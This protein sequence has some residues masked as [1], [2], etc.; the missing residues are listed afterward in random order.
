MWQSACPPGCLLSTH[1]V[2]LTQ[3]LPVL[4]PNF[5]FLVACCGE[6]PAIGPFADAQTDMASGRSALAC[7]GGCWRSTHGS[8]VVANG[9]GAVGLG[10]FP[11]AVLGERPVRWWWH[12]NQ[13]LL[14][15]GPGCQQTASAQESVPGAHS[16]GREWI[17]AASHVPVLRAERR[18]SDGDAHAKRLKGNGQ[19]PSHE[20]DGH[21]PHGH[22]P[23]TP[24]GTH[25][26]ALQ[27]KGFW[28]AVEHL[29]AVGTCQR[30]ATGTL[31]PS[32]PAQPGPLQGMPCL[33]EEHL[34]FR[35]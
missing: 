26:N 14:A 23:A 16:P 4:A 20:G 35:A 10:R 29:R 5:L 3:C 9:G 2:L 27:T 30:A 32:P 1:C 24:W 12:F 21:L 34:C 15:F 22:T 13:P 7:C 28:V 18:P 8:P 17:G 19:T 25:S 33:R 31:P 6:R 11:R